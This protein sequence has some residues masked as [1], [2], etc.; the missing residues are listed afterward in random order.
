MKL[1]STSMSESLVKWCN[2]NLL[3]ININQINKRVVDLKASKINV[4]PVFS[5]KTCQLSFCTCVSAV[6]QKNR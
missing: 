6:Q 5:N 1:E 3:K 4:S 2:N